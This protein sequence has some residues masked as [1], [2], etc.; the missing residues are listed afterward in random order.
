TIVGGDLSLLG[1]FFNATIRAGTLGGEIHVATETADTSVIRGMALWWG[2]GAEPFSTSIISRGTTLAQHDRKWNCGAE[3]VRIWLTYQLQY[4]P[5][6]AD[7]TRKLLGP[8]GKLDSWYL[9][10]FAVAP[11][12]QRQGVAAALIEAAR[13][14][15]SA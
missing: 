6:F 11:Q 3:V 9:S 2:P 1:S 10:L 4:R 15:A 8:Q 14:K 13:G 7:L 5:E 12:H